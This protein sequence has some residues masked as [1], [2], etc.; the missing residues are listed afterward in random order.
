[1]VIEEK[2][3]NLFGDFGCNVFK[4]NG[5]IGSVSGGYHA[6]IWGNF[7]TVLMKYPVIQL[8]RSHIGQ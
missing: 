6:A 7:K 8:R 2:K 1:M 4:C 3:S 5:C